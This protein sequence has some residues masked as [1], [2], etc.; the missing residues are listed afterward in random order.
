MIG[1]SGGIE[2]IFNFLYIRKIES[3]YDEDV[4]YKVYILIVKEYMDK[5]GII[6]EECLLDFFVIVMNIG[7]E[8][9]I[10]M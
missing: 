1:I 5:K 9:R 3:L 10:N 4:Y 8:E 7:Y 6:D 2:F